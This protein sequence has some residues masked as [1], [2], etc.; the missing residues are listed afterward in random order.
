M[1]TGPQLRAYREKRGWTQRQLSEL[2]NSGL[3][4]KYQAT[5]VSKWE[6]DAELVPKIVAEFLTNLQLEEAFSSDLPTLDG[7][8]EPPADDFAPPADLGDDTAPPAPP[9]QERPPFVL[10]VGSN[11]YARVC[12]E[13]WEMIATGIG[14]VGAATGSD[15]LKRDGQIIYG[16]KKELGRAWGKLAET[17]QTFQRMLVGATSGGATL[18]LALVT[19][20]TAGKVIRNHQEASPRRPVAVPDL[21]DEGGVRFNGDNGVVTFPQ[22]I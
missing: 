5:K 21:E 6:R 1:M 2:L 11:P 15:T 9:G 3:D 4:R 16:D 22:T 12:E 13:L 19:G 20:M 17:N 18:Q 7:D 14:I 8:Y 10:P